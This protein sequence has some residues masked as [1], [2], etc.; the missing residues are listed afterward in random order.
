MVVD[1]T[2]EFRITVIL[3]ACTFAALAFALFHWRRTGR[4]V[5]LML[6]LSGG[7]IMILEPMFDTVGGCWFPAN[8]WAAFTLWGRPIPVW[9]CLAYFFYFGIGVGAL[10]LA[11]KQGITRSQLWW[12]FASAMVGDFLFEFT[13]LRFDPYVYYGY[14]PLRLEKFPLWWAPVNAHMA[15]VMAAVIYRFDDFFRGWKHLAIPG[16]AFVVCPGIN[17]AVAWPSW[18]VIN[19]DLGWTATQAGGLLTYAIAFAVTAFVA[20][21]VCVPQR[22]TGFVRATPSAST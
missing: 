22:A 10:W 13:L 21:A 9:L 8:S 7:A 19:S 20:S 17:A 12:L 1:P 5:F 3:A 18:L 4:P 11:M 16:V 6:F 15:L 2:Y 14:Q